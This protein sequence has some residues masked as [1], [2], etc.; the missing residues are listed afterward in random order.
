MKVENSYKVPQWDVCNIMR[1]SFIVALSSDFFSPQ[2][3][4]WQTGIST[5]GSLCWPLVVT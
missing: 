1:L 5:V 2:V 4:G 3:Q